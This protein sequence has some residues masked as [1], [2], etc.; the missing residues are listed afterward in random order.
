MMLIVTSSAFQLSILTR[1]S[2]WPRGP[3]RL[4]SKARFH[5]KPWDLA[6]L[7]WYTRPISLSLRTRMATI[8]DVITNQV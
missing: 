5:A 8:L 6:I 4:P 1:R 2:P 3:A 7:N